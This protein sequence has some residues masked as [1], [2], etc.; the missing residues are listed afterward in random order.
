MEQFI[1]ERMEC[2]KK[3]TVRLNIFRRSGN[4]IIPLIAAAKYNG[5][6][7]CADEKQS[8]SFLFYR[9]NA[10]LVDEFIE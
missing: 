7:K 3:I 4:E 6:V 9:K 1:S 10:Y 5:T 2:D 8:S